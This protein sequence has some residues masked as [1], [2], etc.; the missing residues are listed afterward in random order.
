M[1]AFQTYIGSAFASYPVRWVESPETARSAFAGESEARTVEKPRDPDA[2]KPKSASGDILDISPQYQ[3]SQ[4]LRVSETESA[5]AEIDVK[6]FDVKKA[7]A[8]IA[9][10]K[11][12]DKAA[13]GKQLESEES[14]QSEES[15]QSAAKSPSGEKLT[16]EEEQQ[17]AELKARDQ[18]VR[19]HEQAH[20]AA[21]GAYVTSGPS[22]TYQTGPDGKKYAVG[23]EVGIDT[24]AVSGDPQATIQ[25]MQVVAAAAL[26]PAEPSGQDQKVAAAARQAVAKAR[27]ELA[28][29]QNAAAVTDSGE[30]TSEETTG[31]GKTESSSKTEASSVVKAFAAGTASAVSVSAYKAQSSMPLSTPSLSS[32]G[33][34][35]FA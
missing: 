19:V 29:Q 26:A 25:K 2:D 8:E 33:F 6:K 10:S 14:E 9:D 20:I 34:T 31:S 3:Q 22:Y 15:L 35:V 12:A 5:A 13:D 17:V 7:D 23:G 27:M 28:A 1:S 32:R 30:E 18:E 16:P 21:G 4:L 11:V 24:G